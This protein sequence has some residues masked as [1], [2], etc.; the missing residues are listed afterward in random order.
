MATA[1]HEGHKSDTEYR[2]AIK[3]FVCEH[4]IHKKNAKKLIVDQSQSLFQI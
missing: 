4:D 1:I 3:A 2:P